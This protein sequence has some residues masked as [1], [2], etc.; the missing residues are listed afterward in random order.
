MSS[1]TVGRF[2]KDVQ[3]IMSRIEGGMPVIQE[4]LPPRLNACTV[5]PDPDCSFGVTRDVTAT[6]DGTLMEMPVVDAVSTCTSSFGA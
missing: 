1:L 4:Q 6:H 2:D 3:N 5:Y